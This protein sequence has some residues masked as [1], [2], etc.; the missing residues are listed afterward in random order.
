MK[1]MTE[2]TNGFI[3][4]EE[5]LKMRGTGEIFGTRQSGLPEF[6]VADIVEDFAIVEEARK[7]ATQVVAIENWRQD[8]VWRVVARHLDKRDYLD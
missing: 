7:V 3:L 5:D 1:I 6:K 4:A 8:P 2:T